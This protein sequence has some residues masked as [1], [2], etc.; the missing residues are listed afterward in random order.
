MPKNFLL[1]SLG[2]LFILKS[3]CMPNQKNINTVEQL[4]EKIAKARSITFIDFL[5]LNVNDI[6]DFRQQMNQQDAE[7]VITKNT[8]MKLALKDQGIGS[9]EINQH[10]KGPTA[11]I[12]SYQDPVAYLKTL[13]EFAK[14]IE[15]PK[16][17]FA[18]IEGDYT[19][20]EK[21]RAISEL[22][23]RE[24]LLAKLVSGLNAP[25][26]GFANMIGGGQRKLVT[27]LSKI[28]ENKD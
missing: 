1:A 19:E 25:L 22:P 5:G 27:V 12:F 6:N 16:V 13:F 21:V 3:N 2:T 24:E 4:K 9:E 8:L 15:L 14:E 28:A 18:L 26:A 17:K 7:P 11:V 20:A 23:S 10:L